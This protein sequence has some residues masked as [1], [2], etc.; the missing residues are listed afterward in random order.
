MA[1]S[2][3]GSSAPGLDAII[4]PCGGGG[5]L[6]G[7]ALSCD[8]TSI[9]VYGADDARRGMLAGQRVRS[10]ASRTVADGL[11]TLLGELPWRVLHER[12]LVSGMHSVPDDD[13]LVAMRLVLERCKMVVEPST[14]VG[15]AVALFDE[16]FRAAVEA[17]AGDAGWD[18]GVVLRG[19]NVDADGLG[20][21]F[22][23][24]GGQAGG[25]LTILLRGGIQGQPL[26]RVARC[27][28]SSNMYPYAKS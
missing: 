16:D 1:G 22:G 21:L 24:A 15:L 9:R 14:C 5:L 20:R 4:V 8:G 26:A 2:G 17:A 11:R 19:G 27:S 12:R 28:E 18:L 13:I 23:G 3:G 7:I 6:A 25:E 10:V